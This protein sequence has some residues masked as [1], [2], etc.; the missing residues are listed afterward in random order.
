MYEAPTSA[1]C[2][3]SISLSIHAAVQVSQVCDTRRRRERATRIT[4]WEQRTSRAGS[5]ELARTSEAPGTDAV[6]GPGC[7][8]MRG[9]STTGSHTQKSMGIKVLL[10]F[11]PP[12]ANHHEPRMSLTPAQSQTTPAQ[13]Q[14]RASSTPTLIPMELCVC[15]TGEVSWGGC[16]VHIKDIKPTI[17]TCGFF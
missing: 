5:L 11:T 4:R 15:A 9:Q 13:S 12:S 14:T 2:L 17:C 16:A 8:P 6:W 3:W 10:V 1:Q 7:A